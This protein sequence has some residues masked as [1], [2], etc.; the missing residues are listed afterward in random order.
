MDSNPFGPLR[1]EGG[2]VRRCNNTEVIFLSAATAKN[3]QN[4]I[5]AKYGSSAKQFVILT[6]FVFRPSGGMTTEI[7]VPLARSLIYWFAYDVLASTNGAITYYHVGSYFEL[8]GA[9]ELIIPLIMVGLNVGMVMMNAVYERRKEIRILSMV[10]L[11]P[12]HIGLMFVAEAVILGMVGGSLGYL[13]GLGF[14]RTMVLFG[15]ELMVRE[16]LEWWWSAAGF[17]LAMI[18]SVVSSIRPAALAVST[19]TPSM[20]KKVKRTE[21]QAKVR[22]EEIFK[23]YQGRQMSMPVKVLTSEKEFFI[24]FLLDRLYELKDGFVERVENVVQV[25]ETE[26]VKGELVLTINFDYA[27]GATGRERGTKNS[28]VMT[29]SPNEDYYRVRLVSEPAVMGLPE[30]VIE[31][32]IDLIHETCLLWVKDKGKYLGTV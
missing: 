9:A 22:R 31:R 27:F 30:T 3:I 29:K 12:T 4:L 2:E 8:K 14:S 5:D 7:I 28:L 18:A 11:N 20:V 21:K 6:D 24:S 23:V 1:I 32:T 13:I 15:Q 25:P 17:A 10:G 26:D 19:Y 16:K